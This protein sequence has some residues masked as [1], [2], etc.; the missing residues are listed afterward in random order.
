MVLM[1]MNT[2]RAQKVTPSICPP[3]CCVSDRLEWA[4]GRWDQGEEGTERDR[5]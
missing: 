5:G 2:Q 1:Q 4:S 3:V